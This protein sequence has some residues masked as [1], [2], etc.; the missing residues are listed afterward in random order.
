[1]EPER[2]MFEAFE[3]RRVKD[4]CVDM[5]LLSQQ[6]F[7]Q[8]RPATAGRRDELDGGKQQ[9]RRQDEAGRG[10]TPH[11]VVHEEAGEGQ[12]SLVSL[13]EYKPLRSIHIWPLCCVCSTRNCVFLASRSRLAARA[14]YHAT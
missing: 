7:I 13:G 1:M 3:A 4:L 2:W 14:L 12:C 6:Q 5:T 11:A 8:R 9:G 10:Q